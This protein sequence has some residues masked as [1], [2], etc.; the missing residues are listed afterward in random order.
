M[1]KKVIKISK[2]FSLKIKGTKKYLSWLSSHLQ[3]EHPKTKGKILEGVTFKKKEV[4]YG[5]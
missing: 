5:Q 2:K 1:S 3:K 4:N